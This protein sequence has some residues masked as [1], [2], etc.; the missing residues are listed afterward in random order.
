MIAMCIALADW[1]VLVA[2]Y[3]GVMLASSRSRADVE[4]DSFSERW[5]QHSAVAECGLITAGGC[6]MLS[7]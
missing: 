5:W 1:V 6:G 4:N 3:G 2:F 7:C